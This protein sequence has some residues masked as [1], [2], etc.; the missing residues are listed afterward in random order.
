MTISHRSYV[1]KQVI[2]PGLV[3]RALEVNKLIGVN[4]L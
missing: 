3:N 1:D 4:P 2:S